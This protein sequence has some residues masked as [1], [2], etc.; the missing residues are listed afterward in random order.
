ML[1]DKKAIGGWI[2]VVTILIL[3]SGGYFLFGN[4]SFE[5]YNTM[6]YTTIDKELAEFVAL[7]KL[8]VIYSSIN[9]D[10]DL[11]DLT[12]LA[13]IDLYDINGEIVAYE[14][15]FKTGNFEPEN[16]EELNALIDREKDM[17]KTNV[18]IRGRYHKE[19][20]YTII[21][22]ARDTSDIITRFYRALSGSLVKKPNLVDKLNNEYPNE[23]LELGR[24]VML[25][26]ADVFYEVLKNGEVVYLLD[27]S[28][29]ED[30]VKISDM[31]KLID[32]VKERRQKEWEELSRDDKKALQRGE[33]LHAESN[34]ATWKEYE[35]EFVNK[36]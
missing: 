23:D 30:L 29:K 33:V 25:F 2:L 27:Y 4:V 20:I 13:N 26:T 24:I 17:N 32:E 36:D 16:L 34:I 15:I 14:F 8:D 31:R 7:K 6:S 9:S 21:V 12:Y 35:N 22:G 18:E 19:N 11:G 3:I 1:M 28:G 10:F 5:S